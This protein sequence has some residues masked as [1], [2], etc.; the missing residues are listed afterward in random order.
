MLNHSSP[1]LQNCKCQRQ[2][3]D[4]RWSDSKQIF[5]IAIYPDS[6]FLISC[7][8]NKR[9]KNLHLWAHFPVFICQP[10]AQNTWSRGHFYDG[11]LHFW[12]F[13]SPT[14][15]HTLTCPAYPVTEAQLQLPASCLPHMPWDSIACIFCE[16]S[17][18]P[19]WQVI[20]LMLQFYLI[21][22]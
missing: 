7:T 8:W 15:Y 22:F 9:F 4:S 21:F 19:Q 5:L 2:V 6:R 17:K 16:Y 1:R 12:T 20:K 11:F 10:L 3:L 18:H 13:P 14:V